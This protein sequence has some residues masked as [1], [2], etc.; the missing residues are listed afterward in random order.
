[1]KVLFSLVVVLVLALLAYV[2]TGLAPGQ[3]FFGVVMPY[4][5]FAVFL[6]GLVAKIVRWARAPVPFRIPSTCG[7]QKS[8]DWIEPAKYDN[9]HNVFG[10][11]VRMALEVLAFRSL[12]RNIKS[13][14][15][16]GRIIHGPNKWLWL[17]ALAFH[18]SFLVIFIRHLRFFTEPVPFFVHWAESLDGFFQVGVPFLFITDVVIVLAVTYLFLRRVVVPQLRY[19]SLPA[20]YF[21]LFLILGI[22]ISGILLRYFVKTDIVAV[23]SLALSLVGVGERGDPSQIHWLFYSHLFLVC[24]LLIYF[25]FSKLMHMGGVFL[26]PTRNL[27]NNNRAVRHINPWNPDIKPHSYEA[28]EDEFRERMVEC[29]LPV[30]KPLQQAA[31]AGEAPAAEPAAPPAEEE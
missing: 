19:I 13:E 21:P 10:V 25:P 17:A 4:L 24:S 7:Q 9:P 22:A 23:K 1:M 8:L 31:P 26:S 27:V 18:Y 15:K 20:D 2:G 3:I 30:D 29:G 28:Y 6:V 5:A 11:I 16:D 12:F 14:V